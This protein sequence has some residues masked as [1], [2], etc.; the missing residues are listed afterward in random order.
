M[1]SG[2][3]RTVD[4]NTLRSYIDNGEVDTVLVVFPDHQGRLVGKRCDAEFY[5]SVVLEEGTENCNYLIATDMDNNAVP[6]YRFANYDL[7]YGDMRSVV[8]ES[9][10]RLCPWLEKTALVICDL[11]DVGTEQPIDVSPRQILKAQIAAAESI[12]YT[13]M[14]GSEIEFFLFFDTYQEAFEKGYQKLRNHSPFLEDYHILQTTKDEYIVGQLRRQL[15]AA[16]LPIETTKGEAG[17]GQ[18]ELNITYMDALA[19]A[20]ANA[21]FK[22]AAKEI[23]ALNG[24]SISFMA[25][26]D[27]GDTGSSYHIHSSLWRDGRSVMAGHDAHH[28]SSEFRWYLGGLL[29]TAREFSLLYAPTINSYSRFQPGSWAPTAIGWGVDNRTLGFRVVGH[30]QGMRVECRVPGAD[31]NGYHA[32]AATLAAGL[33]GI[34][35]QI[36]PGEPYL[37]NGYE[38]KDLDRI[39]WNIVDAIELWRNST[40]ARE[41]F[42]DDVHHHVLNAAE[43]EW[44]AF[45]RHVSDWELRR[46]FERVKQIEPSKL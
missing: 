46:Y 15:K 40:V 29:Q 7:G 33:Y 17:M 10:I 26:Y 35:H 21:F 1:E 34:R 5:L 27:M 41:C 30:G 11:E 13:P 20:D 19:M 12:G 25:K 42:G 36:D 18:H 22:N 14:L 45:N 24:R 44:L 16:G 38:A 39:P 6:G 9:T 3:N 32:F 4:P 31:A 43:Q 2:K 8:D 37:T 23:A 28:M